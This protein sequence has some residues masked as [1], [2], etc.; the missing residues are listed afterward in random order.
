VPCR[1]AWPHLKDTEAEFGSQGLKVIALSDEPLS[2]VE[3]YVS[4]QDLGFTVASGS[5]SLATYGVSGIPHSVLIDADGN[6]A[7]IG[8]P[9]GL[10][11]GTVKKAL[12]GAKKPKVEF[13]SVHLAKGVE[14]R[15]AKAAD[16]AADGQLAAAGKE[17]DALLA[18]AKADDGAKAQAGELR[19]AIEKHVKL[20][21]DQ[22]EALVK[23]REPELAI[24]L[25]DGVAK[26][27]PSTEDGA[28]AKKRSEEI[29]ADPKTKAE[30][31]ASK[32]LERLKTTI[33]PLKKDKARPAI[34]EFAKK[35]EGTKAAERAKFLL[36]SAKT[37]G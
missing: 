15:A 18:D 24:R 13:L 12:K 19:A 6:I 35:Y 4:Q 32:A 7:W 2:D 28:R 26:E 30:L 23:D 17:I 31:D 1:G 9:Y 11:K 3:P 16:L 21:Q 33:R 22:A 27:F 20:L 8:S 25:L 36:A 14:G 34:E 29:A 37:K 10:S 5:K